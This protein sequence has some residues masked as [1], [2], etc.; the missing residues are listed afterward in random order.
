MCSPFRRCQPYNHSPSSGEKLRQ[1][2]IADLNRKIE[3]LRIKGDHFHAER[4]EQFKQVFFE[5]P[6]RNF[7]VLPDGTIIFKKRT[8]VRAE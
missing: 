4:L 5:D 7:D 2:I 1:A 3:N 6:S 8:P